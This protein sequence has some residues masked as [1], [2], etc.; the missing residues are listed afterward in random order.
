LEHVRCVVKGDGAVGEL[1]LG[2][3]TRKR[4]VQGS[5]NELLEALGVGNLAA[6]ATGVE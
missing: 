3:H 6:L 4:S 1:V 2:D 5:S